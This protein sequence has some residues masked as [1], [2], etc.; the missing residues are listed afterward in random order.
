MR[1]VAQDEARAI[2]FCVFLQCEGNLTRA[3]E[4]ES[5]ALT[6]PLVAGSLLPAMRRNLLLPT[7]ILLCAAG[8][9]LWNLGGAPPGPHYDEAVNVILTRNIAF[10]GAR[11]FPI[12]PSYQGR[13][14]LYYYLGTPIFWTID[15]SEFGLRL[16]G[17]YANLL[18]VAA[19]VALGRRMFPRTP[20]GLI[21]GVVA[22]VSLP[23]VL[24]AR[25]AFRAITLPMLQALALLFLWHGLRRRNRWGWLIFGGLLA[26]AT[27]YTYMA[28]RLFPVWL[29]LGGLV[30]VLTDRKIWVTRLMQGILF[31]AV[32]GF[33]A[34]PML[35]FALNNPDLFLGRLY[36]VS[37]GEVTFGESVRRHLRMFFVQGETLLRYNPRGRPY[38]TPLEGVLLI[39]G[40]GG[41]AWTLFARRSAALTRA[42]AM[43]LLLSPLMVL[44]SVISTGGLPPNHMRSIGMVPLIF[45][46]VGYGGHLVLAWAHRARHGLAPTRP[47]TARMLPPNSNGLETVLIVAGLAAGVFITGRDYAAWASRADLY[48]ATDA[49][50]ATAADW[51]AANAADDTV[52]IAAQDRAHPTV[53]VAD[54]LDDVRWLGTDTLF[55][56]ANDALVIFPRSAPPSER[57]AR[58]LA[59][60]A[61]TTDLPTGPDGRPAFEAYRV[62]PDASLPAEFRPAE[63][64]NGLLD[65]IGVREGGA[66]AGARGE[67]IMAWEVTQT[68]STDDLTPLLEIRDPIGNLLHR[69][70]V[71][72]VDAKAWQP[73]ETL[74]LTMPVRLPIGTPPGPYTVQT[75]WVARGTEQYLPY[76]GGGLWTEVG[77]YNVSRPIGPQSAD[78]LPMDTRVEVDLPEGVRLL[79]WDAPPTTAR[80]G[81][82]IPL[83][84]YWRAQVEAPALL[85]RT[86]A[87]DTDTVEAQTPL[88]GADTR[89]PSTAWAAGEI[90]TDRIRVT[91]SREQPAGDYTLTLTAGGAVVD[92]G[93]LTIDGL[94]RV[95]S[96]PPVETVVDVG[97]GDA[98]RLHGYTLR[99]DAE[100]LSVDVVW[101]ADAPVTESYTVFVHL[102]DEAG[103]IQQQRD[104][105]P[106]SGRYPTNLW[107]P[108]E[109]VTDTFRFEGGDE[110]VLRLGWYLPQTGARLTTTDGDD[111]L[112]I[113]LSK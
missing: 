7:L 48:Y 2:R 72:F 37:G 108:G 96:P 95:M 85:T 8:L 80:P 22:A 109:Y 71:Y 110:V 76:D 4:H 40:L 6:V 61:L 91:I 34:A 20:V 88:R 107:L 73:G 89:Y 101:A 58:W 10:G 81:E 49:D 97:F 3:G 90:V 21:A 9:R 99:T 17:V 47:D 33:I 51:L 29:A 46:A 16:L 79:G 75:A 19:T 52:Y 60:Y 69:S 106:M 35:R 1:I 43:L 45:V 65:L 26:G 74:L 84:V 98:L 25:Q 44:P 77:V 59:P 78:G 36:E 15:D 30:L 41:A 53:R 27:I 38:F 100:G 14:V 105:V 23:Q 68:P 62:P 13:E 55:L 18:T 94:P 113:L 54:G 86:Y 112:S 87:L 93:N 102:V 103:E 104:S 64:S 42:A 56:P 66:Y 31:F 82:S 28:S 50:L 83:T 57:W 11:F 24:L 39:I 92:L 32:M 67:V 12:T 5:L 70:D 111:H 63:A